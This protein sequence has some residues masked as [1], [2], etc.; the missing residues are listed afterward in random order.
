MLAALTNLFQQ[1]GS[2]RTYW[3]AY[4]GGLDSQ[5]LLHLCYQLRDNTSIH[6][7]AIHINHGLSSQAN[8]WAMHCK[9]TCAQL[10]IPFTEHKIKINCQQGDSL[11]EIARE[12]RYAIFANTLAEGDVLLTAHHQDDQAE[13]LLLQLFRGAGPKGLASM[14]LVKSFA[15]GLH[16]R[17]LLSFSRAELQAYALSYQLDWVEDESNQNTLFTRNFIRHEVM[18]LLRQRWPSIEAVIARSA[19]HCAETQALLDELALE[20]W[21]AVQGS[22]VNTLSV[23]KLLL[24]T[25]PLQKLILRMWIPSLGFPLPDTKKIDTILNNVLTANSDRHPCVEWAKTELR[26]YRD[27]LY[28]I[29]PLPSHDAG[30]VL[31]WNLNDELELPAIGRLRAIPC[32][33]TGLCATIQQVSVRFRQLGD[34]VRIGAKRRTLKNLFQ[35]WSVPTWQ[36]HRVPLLFIDDELIAGVGYFINPAYVAK[37]NEKGWSLRLDKSP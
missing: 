8:H 18:P 29:T 25:K 22:K 16:A 10:N 24:L 15:Q 26:R 14:P 1:Y 35:E 13:T 32:I 31:N 6:L 23:S 20:K 33:E 4:S 36:R 30:Q 19:E 5:V 28:L 37:E 12:K 27:D 7:R 11:E 17:P 21:Q 3:V 34:K 2:T 9:N